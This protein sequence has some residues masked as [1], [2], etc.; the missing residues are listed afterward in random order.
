MGKV[1]RSMKEKPTRKAMK[2][3][4]IAMT[5]CAIAVVASVFGGYRMGSVHAAKALELDEVPVEINNPIAIVNID[6]GIV[7]NETKV[8]YGNDLIKNIS[9]DIKVTGLGDA[10]Q[11]IVNGE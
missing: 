4:G 6:E 7:Q 10:R 11:G 9:E 5:V 8:N 1:L 3:W 2:A